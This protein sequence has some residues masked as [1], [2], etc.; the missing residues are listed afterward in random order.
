[1][2]QK[3]RIALTVPDDVDAVL[4]KLS[5]LTG[6]P[7]TRIIMEMLQE[8]LPIFER[9]A[10]ALEQIVSDKENAIEIA[11]KF[12]SEL[13]LDGNEKLGIVASEVKNL[14]NLK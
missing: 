12:A 6:A 4:E 11:K 13:L 2:A 10:D 14:G 1:M 7:K 8:Y 5:S 3:K 9:T